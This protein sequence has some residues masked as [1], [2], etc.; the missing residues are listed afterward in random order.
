M[1]ICNNNICGHSKEFAAATISEMG[2]TALKNGSL[3]L[4]KLGYNLI[5]NKDLLMEV[6]NEFKKDI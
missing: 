4:A 6:K 5:C 3:A 1:K 2:T